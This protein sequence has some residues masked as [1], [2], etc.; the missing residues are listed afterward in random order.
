MAA[1]RETAKSPALQEEQCRVARAQKEGLTDM[2]LVGL[3]G[4]WLKVAG[5]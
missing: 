2:L 5:G 4:T 1:G 3:G